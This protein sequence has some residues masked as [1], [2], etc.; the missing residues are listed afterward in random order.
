MTG[1]CARERG[2]TLVEVVVAVS[3]FSLVV[4]AALALYQQAVLSWHKDEAGVDV[5]ES[6]RIGLDRMSR[7]LRTAVKFNKASK[8]SIEFESADGKTVYY[9]ANGGQLMRQ[10]NPSGS[11]PVANYVTGLTLMYYD[12]NNYEL[13]M[14]DNRV[15]PEDLNSI[16]QVEITLTGRK[17][18]GP[19]IK[20]TTSVRIRALD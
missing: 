12:G 2:F 17:G 16:R 8:N 9:E 6:L 15:P 10:V 4:G 3:I 14:L 11:N 7:E 18:N 20:M 19:E 1:G 5:Q 13:S